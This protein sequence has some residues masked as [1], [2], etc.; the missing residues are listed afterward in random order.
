MDCFRP[1]APTA[2]CSLVVSVVLLLLHACMGGQAQLA[3][4]VDS[5][6]KSPG[7]QH[8]RPHLI[9]TCERVLELL[10]KVN[11]AYLRD[12]LQVTFGPRGVAG[13]CAS[14]VG[15]REHCKKDE[16]TCMGHHSVCPS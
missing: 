4:H 16:A 1:M 7:N 5:G 6:Q 14:N 2:S 3:A 15:G 12:E 13:S 8:R 10:G 9:P 11:A